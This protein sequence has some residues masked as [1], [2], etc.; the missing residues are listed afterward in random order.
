VSNSGPIV[1]PGE[2]ERLF[3]PFQRLD[4]RRD[5][6]RGGLGLG[7]SI[8]EAIA[9]AHGAEAVARA[10]PEGGLVVDVTFPAMSGV[11]PRTR[12]LEILA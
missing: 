1:P 2:L 7:L 5:A 9:T 8:V 3:Q 11:A 12:E 10:R 6:D 4:G